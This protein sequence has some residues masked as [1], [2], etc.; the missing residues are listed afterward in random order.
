MTEKKSTGNLGRSLVSIAERTFE[1]DLEASERP[2]VLHL[3]SS[4]GPSS[5]PFEVVSHID[6]KRFDVIL[7]SFYDK[8][9][10]RNLLPDSF[11]GEI[12]HIGAKGKLDIRAFF[13]L[14]RIIKKTSPSIL[15][16]HH[17]LEGSLGRL[18][19]K[20]LR[21]PI[22]VTTQHADHKGYPF[23][24]NLLNGLT[25]NL[26]DI[27]ICNSENTKNS[28]LSWENFLITQGK[29]IVV[30]NGVNLF[31]IDNNYISG[32]EGKKMLGINPSHLLIGNV[33]RLVSHKDQKTL[34]QAMAKVVRE[35]PHI[36]LVIV[37]S[38]E[39]ENVLKKMAEELHLSHL[40]LFTGELERNQVYKIL[41]SL[42]IFVMS[43][44]REG[45]CNAVA[46]AM[47]AKKT[48]L[49]ATVGPLLEVVGSA[50]QYFTPGDPQALAEAILNLI[51]NRKECESIAMAGRRRVEE[52]FTLEKCVET[53]ER[54]YIDLLE[55]K[56][57]Q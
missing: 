55:K 40:I 10:D 31:K 3:V 26:S 11:K 30:Y 16:V 1:N 28:F 33:G 42:D 43:S 27:I 6:G 2:R 13:E 19:A 23:L 9:N 18:F 25:L 34:I 14:Y 45:F 48:V 46:E 47:A 12:I 56:R 24:G 36:N 15:H 29:K 35:I 41:H 37:G 38:G 51:R 7:A 54:L 53:Y 17:L 44:L 49:A 4:L 39:L 8:H 32:F 52:K 57:T 50:G 20:M 21:V 22:I 5:I